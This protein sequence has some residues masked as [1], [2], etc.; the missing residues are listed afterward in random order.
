[1]SNS[2]L[3]WAWQQE[4]NTASEK[5]VLVA[6]ADHLGDQNGSAWPGIDRLARRC[7]ISARTAIRAI[8]GLVDLGLVTRT[9]RFQKSNIYTLVISDRM[10]HIEPPISDT[11]SPSY[12]PN[13]HPISDTVSPEPS[14]EPSIEPSLVGDDYKPTP[15]IELSTHFVNTT[16]IQEVP[17]PRWIEACKEMVDAGI[18][19]ADMTEAIMI[20]R[21]KNYK[22]TGPWSVINTAR[23]VMSERMMD[24][25]MPATSSPASETY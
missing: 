14:I 3:N 22:I 12:V 2:A 25:N 16:F 1:M 5:L 24:A 6:L 15:L 23:T 11:V 18:T 13:C 8:D 9:R 19:T 4:T 10:T 21:S 20:L 7:S 17:K